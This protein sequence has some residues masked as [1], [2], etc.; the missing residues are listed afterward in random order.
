VDEKLMEWHGSNFPKFQWHPADIANS[1]GIFLIWYICSGMDL[2]NPFYNGKTTISVQTSGK[3][4][5]GPNIFLCRY[6]I[7]P[8]KNLKIRLIS[9]QHIVTLRFS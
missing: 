4:A 6:D 7:L 9:D 8:M 1:S 3:Y 5:I 2:I